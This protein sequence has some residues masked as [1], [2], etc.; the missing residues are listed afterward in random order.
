MQHEL[1]GINGI[2]LFTLT[3]KVGAPREC[4]R[5]VAAAAAA[6]VHWQCAGIG[7]FDV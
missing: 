5:G 6:A 4:E 3:V 7:G 2:N 1:E